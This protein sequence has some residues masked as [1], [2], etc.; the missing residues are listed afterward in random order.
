[1]ATHDQEYS[2]YKK[3]AVKDIVFFTNALAVDG[4]DISIQHVPSDENGSH[5]KVELLFT[6]SKGKDRVEVVSAA[7]MQMF[8]LEKLAKL[9]ERRLKDFH[10]KDEAMSK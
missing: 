7:R 5:A 8:E 6:Q 4:F 1:M 9:I 2:I 3:E 10:G